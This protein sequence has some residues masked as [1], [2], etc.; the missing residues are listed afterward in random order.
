MQK[1]YIFHT[2]SDARD[3]LKKYKS[4]KD[5]LFSTNP[6]VD[7]FFKNNG[8]ISCKC[9]SELISGNELYEYFTVAMEK[10]SEVLSVF[11]KKTAEV[12]PN[13]KNGNYFSA[14]YSYSGTILYITLHFFI[15]SLKRAFQGYDV[16]HIYIYDL[17]LVDNAVLLSEINKD[18]LLPFDIPVSVLH[19]EKRAASTNTTSMK[20]GLFSLYSWKYFIKRRLFYKGIDY[21]RK[22]LHKKSR[23]N[24][25]FHC[26]LY[27]LEFL[28]TNLWKYNIIT[29]DGNNVPDVKSDQI[30]TNGSMKENIREYLLEMFSENDKSAFEK[31]I[32]HLLIEHFVLH[33]KNHYWFLLEFER[34]YAELDISLL[35]WDLAPI[36]LNRALFV[37][38]AKTRGIPI[39]GTQHGG[40]TGEI[41]S[42]N[43]LLSHFRTSDI[44]LSYGFTND[45]LRRLYGF[46]VD[47]EIYPVG[48]VKELSF[49]DGSKEIDILFPITNTIGM[50]ASGLLRMPP[51]KLHD[52]QVKLLS[53]LNSLTEKS[54]CVKPFRSACEDTLS[55]FPM[56]SEL[57]EHIKVEYD[58]PLIKYL[59][60]YSP[61]VVVMELAS[62]PLIEVMNL[63]TEIFLLLDTDVNPYDS[64]I[65]ELIKKRVH[66]AETAEELIE[67]MDAFFSGKLEAKRNKEYYEKYVAREGS[68]EKILT[69]IDEVIQKNESDSK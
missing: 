56:L 1:V 30:S 9:L 48:K 38:S 61:S 62:T 11:D 20:K 24:I 3:Y 65:L 18:E 35:I 55:V 36:K 8:N 6:A 50:L 12:F 68:K 33:Y 23:K 41:Y 5:V 67:K 4:E 54:I 60:S 43:H 7:V 42:P 59:N 40:I 63:D 26:N 25:L 57:D 32:I 34:V 39:I 49:K 17:I 37:E 47:I 16:D 27:E 31:T 29:F 52:A 44:Y 45:D 13:V 64:Q 21:L 53:Y 51:H 58:T 10:T 2:V 15:L 66:T 46:D 69:I 19:S 28:Y 22:V 14:L